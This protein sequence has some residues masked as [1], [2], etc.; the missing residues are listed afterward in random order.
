M[1]NYDGLWQCSR[2]C[3]SKKKACSKGDCKYWIDYRSEFNCTLVAIYE[4]GKMTLREVADRLG[5][6]FAR[7]K[8]IETEALKKIK[9]RCI[10]KGITF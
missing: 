2:D 3:M 9:K 6:S 8:Q 1:R 7:V 5:I 10:N 4:N